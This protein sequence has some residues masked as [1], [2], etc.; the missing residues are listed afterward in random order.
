MRGGDVRNLL[1]R[2]GRLV[3]GQ[4]IVRSIAVQLGLNDRNNQP[5]PNGTDAIRS[6]SNEV[7]KTEGKYRHQ[8]SRDAR[9]ALSELTACTQSPL[10]RRFFEYAL[11][12]IDLDQFAEI[13]ATEL[14]R[15]KIS[16]KRLDLVRFLDRQFNRAVKAGLA[17]K[18]GLNILDLGCGTGTFCFALKFLGHNVIGLDRPGMAFYDEMTSLLQVMKL[19]HRIRPLEPLPPI[20]SLDV[21]TAYCAAFPKK[22][23]NACFSKNDWTFFFEDLKSRLNPGGGILLRLN[24]MYDLAGLHPTSSEFAEL[25]ELHGGCADLKKRVVTFGSMRR[26]T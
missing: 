9:A 20:Y 26:Q 14:D 5:L 11:N 12:T 7:E 10:K 16:I 19:H 4:G 15:G 2:A 13:Q 25:V 18:T 1:S 17:E 24:D 22:G 21:I 3:P 6:E 23:N 8:P